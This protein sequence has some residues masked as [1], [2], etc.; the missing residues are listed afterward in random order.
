M[1]VE[2]ELGSE[3]WSPCPS[4]CTNV[5]S[6]RYRI[7]IVSELAISGLVPRR[8]RPAPYRRLGTRPI[9]LLHSGRLWPVGVGHSTGCLMARYTERSVRKTVITL[10]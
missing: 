3:K 8:S 10:E 1:V 2:V 5:P 6:D 7:L 9:G 4:A